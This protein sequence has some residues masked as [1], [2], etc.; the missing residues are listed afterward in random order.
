FSV[1]EEVGVDERVDDSLIG[2]I[3]FF[4]L[5]AHADPPVG[6]GHAA[7]GVDVLLRS[8]HPE[9]DFYLDGTVERAGRANGNAAVAQV[10][11]QRGGNGIAKSVLDRDSEHHTR[12]CTAVEV[13][14]E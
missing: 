4:E 1:G 2:G 9:P 7:L 13:V 10:Q 5:N 3:D 12:T 11:R 6:P 14:R 8:G